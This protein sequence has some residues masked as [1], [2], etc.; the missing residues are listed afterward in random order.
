MSQVFI[1][2]YRRSDEL[3]IR[4]LLLDNFVGKKDSAAALAQRSVSVS[5]ISPPPTS[6]EVRVFSFSRGQVAG[7]PSW[8]ALVQVHCSAPVGAALLAAIR[9]RIPGVLRR[10]SNR[11]LSAELGDISVQSSPGAL[12]VAARYVA[13]RAGTGQAVEQI[14]GY[15]SIR[16]SQQY[17][18]LVSHV[19]VHSSAAFPISSLLLIEYAAIHSHASATLLVT[20]NRYFLNERLRCQGQLERLGWELKSESSTV[21]G[22]GSWINPQV[23]QEF[24]P[25]SRQ[26]S[27]ELAAGLVHDTDPDDY[28]IPP[29]ISIIKLSEPHSDTDTRHTDILLRKVC[30]SIQDGQMGLEIARVF[31]DTFRVVCLA[32]SRCYSDSQLLARLRNCRPQQSIGDFIVTPDFQIWITTHL[33]TPW[34]GK[35]N[36]GMTNRSQEASSEFGYLMPAINGSLALQYDRL[37]S[38]SVSNPKLRAQLGFLLV[39]TLLHELCH[40]WMRDCFE[41]VLPDEWNTPPL[42]EGQDGE[43]GRA[44][45]AALLGG[46]LRVSWEENGAYHLERFLKITGLWL[47]PANAQNMSRFRRIDEA[48]IS[49]FYDRILMPE[50]IDLQSELAGVV[51]VDDGSNPERLT[52][53]ELDHRGSLLR[54]CP[55]SPGS[56]F[57]EP[58]PGLFANDKTFIATCALERERFSKDNYAVDQTL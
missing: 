1:R 3:D 6:S 32:L 58:P 16:T 51:R 11:L 56:V 50:P 26:D 8:R 57:P 39:I 54:A 17:R 34:I 44:L 41:S 52:H 37:C 12:F 21:T 43:S 7:S 27:Q 49:R 30:V 24:G 46:D 45:E 33:D 15:C 13:G 22:L 42:F 36:W 4:R 20:T 9:V 48:S 55:A 14:I 5:V 29:K 38:D 18:G 23:V 25:L 40:S 53:L 47:G 28:K 10:Y 31:E 2:K 35:V 19:T